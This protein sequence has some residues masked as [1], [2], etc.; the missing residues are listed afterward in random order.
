MKLVRK[1]P[2]YNKST[3][4]QVMAW[5][6]RG[7]KPLPE[8]TLNKLSDT[9]RRYKAIVNKKWWRNNVSLV[10][11]LS[12]WPVD[13]SVPTHHKNNADFTAISH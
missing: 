3:L 8:S 13:C 2:I 12:R 11:L 6:L 4:V 7:D 9:S 5:C 1:G 10:N